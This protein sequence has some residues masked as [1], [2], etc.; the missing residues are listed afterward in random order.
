M[1][2]IRDIVRYSQESVDNA[3]K[4]LGRALTNVWEA[5]V[6]YDLT[7]LNVIFEVIVGIVVVIGVLAQVGRVLDWFLDKYTPE[8]TPPNTTKGTKTNKS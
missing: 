4:A 5:V 1:T 3:G 2:S 7:N 8:Y 6:T